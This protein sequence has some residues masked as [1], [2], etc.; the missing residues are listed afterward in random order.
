MDRQSLK[1]QTQT[2]SYVPP[3]STEFKV[4]GTTYIITSRHSENAR[5]GLL[6]KIWRL[7]ENDS[8]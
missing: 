4:G 8:E 5:E 3:E 2:T 7:I 6:D 1:K